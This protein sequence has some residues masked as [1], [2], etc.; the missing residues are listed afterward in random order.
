MTDLTKVSRLLLDLNTPADFLRQYSQFA[1]KVAA[2]MEKKGR[3]ATGVES[4]SDGRM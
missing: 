4:P 2:A 3:P 1:A